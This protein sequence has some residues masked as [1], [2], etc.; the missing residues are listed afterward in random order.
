MDKQRPAARYG[1]V[2]STPVLTNPFVNVTLNGESGSVAVSAT[3]IRPT[4]IG[5]VVRI[6]GGPQD[7]RITD[8]ITPD[9]AQYNG[10]YFYG[11]TGITIDG[12]GIKY[13]LLS[14][15]DGHK[16]Y[17]PDT[18]TTPLFQ[19]HSS[20]PYV[21]GPL[22]FR[23]LA[24]LS[25]SNHAI[26]ALNASDLR[27]TAPVL[28]SFEHGVPGSNDLALVMRDDGRVEWRKLPASTGTANLFITGTNKEMRSISSLS[29]FKLEQ[30]PIGTH[31]EVLDMQGKTWIDKM[32]RDNDPEYNK[33][34]AGFIAQ[35]LEE[36]S[37]LHGGTLESLI[38]RD[39]E[40][41]LE[42]VAYDRITAFLIPI[43]KD[44]DLRLSAVEST[45]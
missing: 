22:R 38:V 35:E 12:P 15:A 27:I 29:Q 11:N 42:S 1:V 41:N 34:F 7:R 20:G 36:L 40:G 30:E 24:T 39:W 45:S 10:N 21:Y 8:V 37:A 14:A 2:A 5:D 23:I 28:H 13:T 32:E 25:G 31:Y 16:F 19:V 4:A 17:A 3:T 9:A 18:A 6:E 44:L 33:R 26:Q 43:I